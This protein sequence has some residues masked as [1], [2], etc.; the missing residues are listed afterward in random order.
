[1][2]KEKSKLKARLIAGRQ[3]IKPIIL[4]K[5]EC[6]L[7]YLKLLLLSCKNATECVG[8]KLTAVFLS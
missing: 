1:M 7:I 5:K 2:N 8:N 6:I 3:K 4:V